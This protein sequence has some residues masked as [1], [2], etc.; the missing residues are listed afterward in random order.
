MYLSSGNNYYLIP[1]ENRD[2]LTVDGYRVNSPNFKVKLLSYSELNKI[3]IMKQSKMELHDIHD[4]IFSACFL[5]ILGYEEIDFDFEHHGAVIDTIAEKVYIESI[6]CVQDPIETFNTLLNTL[7]AFDVW[8]GHVSSVLK[9]DFREVTKLPAH[10]IIRL[11][12]IAYVVS[13]Y[14]IPAIEKQE[15]TESKVG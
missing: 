2:I 14:T 1:L 4:E 15:T 13:G 7:S 5:G 12:T 10:E 3:E 9:I 6:K 11:Y 8:A